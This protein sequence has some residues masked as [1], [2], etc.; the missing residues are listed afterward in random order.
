AVLSA[1][2]Q[3][4]AVPA[5][6]DDAADH[7]RAFEA[8]KQGRIVPTTVI[9]DWADKNYRRYVVEVELEGDEDPPTY[10]VEFNTDEG[11]FLEFD[12]NAA[13]GEM[14]RVRGQGAERARRVP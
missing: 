11:N 9:L 4:A 1:K 8:M 13:N 6:D 5:D 2:G 12:F 10:E 3:P 7:V 14:I